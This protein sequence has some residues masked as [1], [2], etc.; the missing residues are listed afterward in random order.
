[1]TG[2]RT[3]VESAG[4]DAEGS[5]RSGHRVECLREQFIG[6][7]EDVSEEKKSDERRLQG[8]WGPNVEP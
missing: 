5:L 1:M 8:Y 4:S 6:M 3:E 2:R 7:A